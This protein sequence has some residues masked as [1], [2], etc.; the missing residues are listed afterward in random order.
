VPHRVIPTVAAT[1][2]LDYPGWA[3]GEF[4]A[5]FVRLVD[6]V[7]ADDAWRIYE[8]LGKRPRGRPPGPKHPERNEELQQLVAALNTPNP[9]PTAQAAQLI[10]DAFPGIYGPNQKAVET[11]IRRLGQRSS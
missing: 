1:N 8:K 9:T 4:L 2:P 10:H 3:E 5:A 11:K 6:R 7:G